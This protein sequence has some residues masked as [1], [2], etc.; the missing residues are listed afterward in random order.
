[1]QLRCDGGNGVGGVWVWCG[2]GR[3]WGM[4]A[5]VRMQEC[6]RL[7]GWQESGCSNGDV[8]DWCTCGCL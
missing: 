5:S 3:Q 6:E 2:R 7:I 8:R 4:D 1:M